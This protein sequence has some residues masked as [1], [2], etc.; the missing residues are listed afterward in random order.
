MRSIRAWSVWVKFDAFTN[1]AHIFDFGDGP[2]LN[3]TFLGILGKGEGGDDAA[4][5]RPW[6]AKC[7]ET[8][9]P[10]SPSGA[11]LVPE[12]TPQEYMRTSRANVD[13][14]S[15]SGP[16]VL[17]RRLAPIDTRP[18]PSDAPATRAT[19]LYEV[20][21]Q[22]L[23]KVQIKVN[24]AVPLQRWTHIVVTAGS[25]DA[26]RPELKV[27]INGNMLFT[28]PEGYLP[29]AKVTSNNYLGKSNW[30]NDLGEYELRDELFNG[31]L[32][33]FRV[34]TSPMSEAKVKRT[35]QWGMGKLGLDTS[36]ESVS[37]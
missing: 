3:N 35:L 19:L 34:Y 17:P 33:D 5:L 9:V 7:P 16:E 1:N 30:M 20:W 6:S 25:M 8:T 24:R 4:M 32:F 18:V 15:C 26:M 2:G 10:P 12:V 11:Q 21:D 36:F 28:Q 22:K 27:Y 37:G 29:Q 14:Y 31:S 23:R 13:E